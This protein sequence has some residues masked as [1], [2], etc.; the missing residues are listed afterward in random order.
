MTLF[1]NLITTV[2]IYICRPCNETFKWCTTC[3]F[4]LF[5][6]YWVEHMNLYTIRRNLDF[7]NCL[8][9]CVHLFGTN[10]PIWS[11]TRD[12]FKSQFIGQVQAL[13]QKLIYCTRLAR[14]VYHI[15]GLFVTDSFKSTVS[16]SVE[17]WWWSI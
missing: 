2:S 13:A 11:P 10:K 17:S 4:R 15:R 8:V 12:L 14:W 6:I 3:F 5:V 16:S 7:C 9:R 1:N